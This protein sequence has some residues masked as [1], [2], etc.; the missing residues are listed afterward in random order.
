M[1]AKVYFDGTFQH[2]KGHWFTDD[3][4]ALVVVF[5]ITVIRLAN[6]GGY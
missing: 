3:D 2:L 1:Y 6:I 5:A 4:I